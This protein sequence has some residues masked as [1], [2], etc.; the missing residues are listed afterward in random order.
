MNLWR[1]T[2]HAGR[3]NESTLVVCGFASANPADSK[4]VRMAIH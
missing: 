4:L 2:A 1:L 3:I